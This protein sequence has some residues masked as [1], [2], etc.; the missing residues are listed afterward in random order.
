MSVVNTRPLGGGGGGSG[1]GGGGG[2]GATVSLVDATGGGAGIGGRAGRIV[3]VALFGLPLSA[4]VADDAVSVD[5]VSVT[6]AAGAATPTADGCCAV[7]GASPAPA[8]VSAAAGSSLGLGPSRP[9]TKATAAMIATAVIATTTAREVPGAV[10][11]SSFFVLLTC[12]ATSRAFSVGAF[13]SW[14]SDSGRAAVTALCGP[15]AV[16]L[17]SEPVSGPVPVRARSGSSRVDNAS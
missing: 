7:T 6:S 8:T 17:G 15:E 3:L 16:A 14:S 2:G 11:P 1:S 4:G 12:C 13:A 5:D 9:N 10:A